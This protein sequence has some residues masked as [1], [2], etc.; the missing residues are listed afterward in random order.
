M[1]CVRG[2]LWRVWA[3]RTSSAAESRRQQ[4][5]IRRVG[6]GAD[7]GRSRKGRNP[8]AQA[9]AVRKDIRR[10]SLARRRAGARNGFLSRRG[11]LVGGLLR[12]LRVHDPRDDFFDLLGRNRRL[13]ATQRGSSLER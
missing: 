3:P 7:A 13:L 8:P 9:A 6:A 2:H 5:T 11:G 10:L 1:T 4:Q 12:V